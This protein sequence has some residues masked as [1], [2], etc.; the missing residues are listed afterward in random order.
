MP[1]S[2]GGNGEAWFLRV[3]R[4]VLPDGSYAERGGLAAA[5]ASRAGQN[6]IRAI[7]VVTGM[8]FTV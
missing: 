8:L 1:H 3:S 2:L 6:A 7:D 4:F 5:A